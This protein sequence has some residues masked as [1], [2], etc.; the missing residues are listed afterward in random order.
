MTLPYIRSEP[1]DDSII[2]GKTEKDELA[3][4]AQ[5]VESYP[6]F[7]NDRGL[8][9]AEGQDISTKLR[10]LFARPGAITDVL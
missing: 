6:G 9:C 1:L 10:P 2:N 3:E 8:W 4:I 7:R 5:F